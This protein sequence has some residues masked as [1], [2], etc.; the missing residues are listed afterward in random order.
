MVHWTPDRSLLIDFPEYGQSTSLTC[1]AFWKRSPSPLCC[2]I[3]LYLILGQ[4]RL[5]CD[6]NHVGW[7]SSTFFCFKR[8][9]KCYT[10]TSLWHLITTSNQIYLPQAYYFINKMPMVFLNQRDD[11]RHQR[12][13]DNENVNMAVQ[14][15]I[16]KNLRHWFSE[17]LSSDWW[18][19]IFP[20]K[21]WTQNV[22]WQV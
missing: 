3:H 20:N 10:V 4:T 22:F 14:R 8:K 5:S 1:L 12:N 18:P 19:E 9:W 6:S 16:T 13:F 15:T 11:M 7:Y 2:M 21:E 17:N